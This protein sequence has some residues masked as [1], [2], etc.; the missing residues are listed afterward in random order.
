MWEDLA[1]LI[2]EHG[3]AVAMLGALLEGETILAL[4][5]LAANRG[6]L[7]LPNLI[8]IGA[9]GGFLGDQFYFA[10]GRHHGARFLARFP[11]IGKHAAHAASLIER[12]PELSIISVRYMY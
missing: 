8:V 2:P 11:G 5:G 4:A 6:Y 9:I 1:R 12:Y 7:A 3:Y 10:I